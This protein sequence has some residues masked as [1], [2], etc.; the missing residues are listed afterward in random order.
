MT[1]KKIQTALIGLGFGQHVAE[2][3]ILTGEGSNF[4][5]LKAVCDLDQEK[6]QAFQSNHP[7]VDIYDDID[8]LLK[9]DIPTITLVTG[10]IGRAKLIDK[11]L[12]AGKDIM[13]TKPFELDSAEAERVLQKAKGLGRI[14]FIN[15]PSSDGADDIE[16]IQNWQEEHQLGQLVAGRWE[17]WYKAIQKADGSWYDDPSLCPA[18]PLF[19]LGIYGINDIVQL[20]SEPDQLH[21]MES[22]I[23]SEKPTPDLAQM[24]I[25][26]KD[27]AMVSM[28]SGWCMEPYKNALSLN[29]YYEN[30]TIIRDSS[31][32]ETMSSASLKLYLPNNSHNDPT[33]DQ[34]FEKP[35]KEISLETE[36]TNHS[37]PWELFH[38]A[39]TQR[40]Y[41]HGK[42]NS[43]A[44]VN[45][46]KII[47][48]MKASSLGNKP[49]YFN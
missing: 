40:K 38:T 10:P 8:T 47:E 14:I 21:V 25:R 30:G 46:I 13:T 37:Y 39:V 28:L 29:L 27:G 18:A 19:R 22:K 2:T 5:E 16:Q 4:I 17:C 7:Q 36:K 45:A 42:S 32:D 35:A 33:R 1:F 44:I 48:G 34:G 43:N 23:L 9:T 3:M 26:F 20:F 31:Y 11:I 41:I 12:D 24:N 49:H 15:S 6:L